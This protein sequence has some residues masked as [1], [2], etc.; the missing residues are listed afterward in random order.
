M[1]FSLSQVPEVSG[2]IFA[3]G[4]IHGC[5][6]ELEALV[7]YLVK[8]LALN[9]S[10][11]LIFQGDYIDRGP[12]SRGVI[13]FLVNF[14]KTF[15]NIIFLKGNHEDMLLNYLGF[16]GN[17]GDNYLSNGGKDFLL[18]YNL[19]LLT[20]PNEIASLLP[21]EHLTFITSL[22]SAAEHS[23]F[24]FV[25]AGVNPYLPLVEQSEEDML[26]I[27][28]EFIDFSHQ[29]HKIVVF[30]HTPFRRV[31]FDLPYKIGIDTGLVFGNMLSCIELKEA[32]LYQVQRNSNQVRTSNFLSL[33]GS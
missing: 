26:W 17:L 20:P 11:F 7:S 2:R 18:S 8:D 13:E 10:D 33:T 9:E 21:E 27:R 25:H 5:V 6:Y 22:V 4:D 30:G 23:R 19:A 16:S 32:L 15:S 3:I 24:L 1:Q 14:R 29:I 12:N 31:F 28:E